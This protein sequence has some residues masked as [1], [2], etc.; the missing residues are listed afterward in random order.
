[1]RIC[2]RSRNDGCHQCC[3]AADREAQGEE[4]NCPYGLCRPREGLWLGLVNS[5]GTHSVFMV[6][7]RSMSTGFHLLCNWHHWIIFYP[8]GCPSR[9][10]LLPL[11]FI[12]C[13]D[14]V[15]VDLQPPHPWNLL[16]S[17]TGRSCCALNQ[18]STTWLSAQWHSMGQN[19]GHQW[20][21]TTD[22]VHNGNMNDQMVTGDYPAR[23]RYK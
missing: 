10:H 17:L 8:S 12:L 18:R 21:D 11:L 7:Q 20:R 14:T 3:P 15:T 5:S 6:S 19:A 4:Q 16:C 9:I 13:M 2:K 23:S 22:I 1:M